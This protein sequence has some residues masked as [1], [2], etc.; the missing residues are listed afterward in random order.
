MSVKENTRKRIRKKYEALK[1]IFDE[2][3]RR[4]RAAAGEIDTGENK[5]DKSA[6]HKRIRREGGGRKKLKAAKFHGDWN[7]SISP[8]FH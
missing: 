8:A 2:R 7:Y 4:Q 3:S 6:E 5:K 1:S